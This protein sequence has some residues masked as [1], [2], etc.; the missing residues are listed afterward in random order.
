[1]KD[2]LSN[3]A[4][5]FNLHPYR[6]GSVLHHID[7][8]DSHLAVAAAEAAGGRRFGELQEGE[9]DEDGS[10]G[11]GRGLHSS[12]FRLNVSALRGI[13]VHLGGV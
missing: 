6:A 8:L 13:G 4:V 7:I 2:P 9:S 3:F 5:N 10:S 11:G 12:T 1:V